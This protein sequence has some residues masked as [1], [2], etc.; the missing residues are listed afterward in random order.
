MA[1]SVH[2]LSRS[3]GESFAL[4]SSSI[5]TSNCGGIGISERIVRGGKKTKKL[6]TRNEIEN[7]ITK[8]I[9]STHKKKEKKKKKE[10]EEKERREEEEKK[11]KKE[12]EEEEVTRERGEVENSPS[13]SFLFSLFLFFFFSSLFFSFLSWLNLKTVVW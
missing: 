8:C 11:N 5:G 6:S 13:Q 1:S 3:W 7:T 2:F 9:I 4:S 12:E 10:E